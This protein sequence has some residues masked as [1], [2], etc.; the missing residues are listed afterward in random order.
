[1]TLSASEQ[2]LIELINAGRLDPASEARA[3]GIGLNDGVTA[4][5]GG[6]L[7]T[8]PMQVLAPN[9]D[10]EGLADGHTQ[11]MIDT[12]LFNHA[13][14]GSLGIGGRIAG[15]DYTGVLTYRENLSAVTTSGR[16]LAEIIQAHYDTLYSSPGHRAATFD[17]NQSEIGVGIRDGRVQNLTGSVNTNVFGARN[18]DPFVT[19]VAYLDSDGDNFYSIGEGLSGIEISDANNVAQTAA[20][21]GY[22]LSVADQMAAITISLDGNDLAALTVDMSD[23]NVKVDIVEQTAGGYELA[24]SG[25]A[26][27]GTGI[28]DAILLGAGHLDLT[29][30]AE[31]NILTG[32]RG[33][34]TISGGDGADRLIGGNGNDRLFGGDIGYQLYGGNGRDVLYGGTGYD[35]LYGGNYHDR[36]YGEAGNDRMYGGGG[37]DRLYGGNGHDRLYGSDGVDLLHGGNGRDVLIGGAGNDRMIGANSHDRLYGGNG[38]DRMYGNSGEDLLVGGNGNDHLNG[39]R[40]DDILTGG[41]GSDQFVFNGGHDTITDFADDI[42][43]IMIAGSL[44]AGSDVSTLLQNADIVAGDTVITFSNGHSLTIEGVTDIDIL[45]NDLSII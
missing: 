9:L 30:N 39:G 29:G 1:M 15:S 10:L 32:N 23:G 35:R 17:E 31:A 12:H 2:Y 11:W 5:M 7:L 3:Q 40:D 45:L 42:D 38:H 20:A 6:P 21:G 25:S 14:E 37:N 22:A 27:L 8:T 43:S 24:L 41:N 28:D 18:T 44:A 4:A 26:E 36:L 13:G 33:N 34:N 16:S 19:G